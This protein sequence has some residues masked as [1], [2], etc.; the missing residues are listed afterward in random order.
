MKFV[1]FFLFF[2]GA[3]CAWEPEND[4]TVNSTSSTVK[5]TTDSSCQDVSNNCNELSY[6]CGNPDYLKIMNKCPK[7]CH[8]CGACD[9][10]TP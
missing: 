2:V 4:L 7:T 5:T 10:S 3:F 9:D 6:L 1:V 8:Y